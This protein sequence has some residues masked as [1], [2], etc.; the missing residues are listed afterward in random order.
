MPYFQFGDTGS[1]LHIRTQGDPSSLTADVLREIAALDP[2]VAMISATTMTNAILER[3]LFMPRVLALF[4]GVFGAI[5]LIL[6]A[7]GL[8]GVA[9][10]M[11]G[12]RTQEIGIRMAL[13]AQRRAVLRMILGNA[14]SLAA[15]GLIVGVAGGF[16]V[17][18]LV[19]SMLMGVSPWVPGKFCR[20]LAILASTTLVAS[21]IP[22]HRAAQVDPTVAL[23]Y[24]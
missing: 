23:R 17:T 12:R 9:S 21:W 16:A 18:P 24:E 3:G 11:V 10:F 4:G 14:I 19:R 20:V 5:A 2:Q 8:Y 6:A 22:A 1:T 15:G 13:G 7:I